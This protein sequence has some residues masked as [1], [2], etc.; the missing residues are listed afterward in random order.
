M[1]R[2]LYLL[3]FCISLG[4]LF[5]C[6][7]TLVIDKPDAVISEETCQG[8]T[9]EEAIA[10]FSDEY[11]RTSNVSGQV[12]VSDSPFVWESGI[13]VPVWKAAECHFIQG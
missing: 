12:T 3:A 11:D 13:V 2:P 6:G 4:V 8:F 10:V 9:I 7:D 5:S 1:R